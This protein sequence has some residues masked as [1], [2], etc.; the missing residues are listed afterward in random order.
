MT[1]ILLKRST[2]NTLPPSY[3]FGE[4]ILTEGGAKAWVVQADNVTTKDLFANEAISISGDASGVGS[5]AISLTL[6]NSGVTAGTYTKITVD[7]KG[8][9]VVGGLLSDAD[10]PDLAHSK[11]SDFNAAAISAA[12]SLRLDQFLAP[13]TALSLG[14]SRISNLAAPIGAADAANKGYV[15]SVVQGLDVKRSVRCATTEQLIMPPSVVDGVTLTP[16]DRY[17]VK[18]QTVTP[19]T[20]G[21][22]IW[23]SS[24]EWGPRAEDADTSE[25]V[26]TGMYVYVEEGLV[27]GGLGFNLITPMPISL[28][29]TPLNFTAFSGAGDTVAGAGLSKSGNVISID[30]T[31]L[32]QASITTLGTISAG[33]WQASPISAAYIGDL[34][35]SKIT[36]F[37]SAVS[38]IAGDAINAAFANLTVVDAGAF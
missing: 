23:V 22:Y 17:L 10:I 16:G 34:T 4:V 13:N 37:S 32:G 6:A 28:G 31:Y 7:A 24:S 8:R 20:N 35:S 25:E 14:G 29:I 21:I 2:G 15:D 5:T 12:Q 36:D 9:A 3:E 30:P 19:E 38:A 27:N 11:I 1:K 18:D 33:V 26:T